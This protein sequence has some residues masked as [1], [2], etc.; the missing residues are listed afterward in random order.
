MIRLMYEQNHKSKLFKLFLFFGDTQ[1]WAENS[2][3]RSVLLKEE[4]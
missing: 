2:V 3:K 1:K 4:E